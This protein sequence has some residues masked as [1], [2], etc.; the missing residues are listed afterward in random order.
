MRA[1]MPAYVRR[2]DVKQ[3]VYS[4]LPALMKSAQRLTA[5]KVRL[6]F[7]MLSMY[8]PLGIMTILDGARSFDT[9]P[10]ISAAVIFQDDV[11]SS[12]DGHGDIERLATLRRDW[13]EVDTR[14]DAMESTDDRRLNGAVFESRRRHHPV[15]NGRIDGARLEA[16]RGA[17]R[18]HARYR[19][20]EQLDVRVRGHDGVTHPALQG[21]RIPGGLQHR[22][23][24]LSPDDTERQHTVPIGDNRHGQLLSESVLQH[25][26]L[27]TV[28]W[29]ST[30]HLEQTRKRRIT[31]NGAY[32]SSTRRVPFIHQK[33]A[34]TRKS[35]LGYSS[36]I[37]RRRM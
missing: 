22:F 12:A 28:A 6:A 13:L 32:I 21:D 30:Q 29:V 11:E 34:L 36:V 5:N 37:V 15:A 25:R 17:L 3:L 9:S 23:I 19:R 24:R 31:L 33:R 16:L 27:Q 35:I 4:I 7:M 2:G 20:H 26:T 14:A 18:E 8:L 1:C 10:D